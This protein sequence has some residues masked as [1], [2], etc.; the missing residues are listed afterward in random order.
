[1]RLLRYRAN[2]RHVPGKDLVIADT[3]SRA[4]LDLNNASK[5]VV[6]SIHMLNEEVEL[7]VNNIQGDW[8]ISDS[9]LDA[10]REAIQCDDDLSCAFEYTKTGWPAHLNNVSAGARPYYPVRAHLSVVDGLLIH[11][12]RVVIP[13]QMRGEILRLLHEGH[14]GLNKCKERACMSVW[15]PGISTELKDIVQV[16]KHCQ[17]N[18]PA[19]IK[20]PRMPSPLPQRPWQKL[21]TDIT[22]R[23]S[24]L[25]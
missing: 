1:M 12:N 24:I 14:Q 16:C 6:N 2:A 20:E 21:G 4:P 5:S 3:L 19:Q 13:G 9:R 7:Y 18:R 15:W 10:I 8:A 17:V 11:D 23:K 25:L 22:T